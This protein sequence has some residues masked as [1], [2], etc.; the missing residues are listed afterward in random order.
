[1]THVDF[2]ERAS[3]FSR[4]EE[5][6][7]EM[8]AKKRRPIAVEVPQLAS[9]RRP[10]AHRSP[11][12]FQEGS[13]PAV[14]VRRSGRTAGAGASC[15]P[16]RLYRAGGRAATSK[17]LKIEELRHERKKGDWYLEKSMGGGPGR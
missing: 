10:N 2:P 6:L 5:S 4:R 1:M 9:A 13:S 14:G 17:L 11:V 7:D 3:S 15:T 8:L 16:A 12:V